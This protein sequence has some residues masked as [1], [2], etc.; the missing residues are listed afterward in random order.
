MSEELNFT[1]WPGH[2]SLDYVLQHNIPTLQALGVED[3][4]GLQVSLGERQWL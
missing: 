3:K 1:R 2:M 4:L